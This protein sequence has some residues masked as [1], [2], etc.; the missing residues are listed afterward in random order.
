MKKKIITI[1]EFF[2]L[3]EMFRGSKE[4]QE[5]AF[6][7]YDSQYKDREILDELMTKALMFDKRRKFADAVQYKFPTKSGKTIY[8]YI[9]E[10]K[11]SAIYKSI[12]DKLMGYD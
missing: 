1:D 12:L 5:L 8:T 10:N 2:R 9:E 3:Q 7:I 4:D 11:M 6:E